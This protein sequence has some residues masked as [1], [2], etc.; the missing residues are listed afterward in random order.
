M[1]RLRPAAVRD[2]DRSTNVNALALVSM[3]ES[4]H[5]GHHAFPRSARHGLLA[6]QFDTSALLIRGF[7][8]AGWA[9]DVHWPTTEAIRNRAAGRRNAAGPGRAE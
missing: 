7:E 3:G 4:W 6:G 5:N 9:T 8:R 2:D 1:P